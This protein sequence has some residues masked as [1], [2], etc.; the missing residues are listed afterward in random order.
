MEATTEGRFVESLSDSG[1]YFDDSC[2][3]LVGGLGGE[4]EAFREI[5]ASC[6]YRILEVLCSSP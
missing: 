5:F 4:G 3:L 1:R 2:V 6:G